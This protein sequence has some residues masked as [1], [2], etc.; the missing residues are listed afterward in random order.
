[1]LQSFSSFLDSS[2]HFIQSFINGQKL[3]HFLLLFWHKAIPAL[4]Q[5]V[6]FFVLQAKSR[7]GLP[8]STE[9]KKL[10]PLLDAL[11]LTVYLPL[12]DEGR[13]TSNNQL[14]AQEL[15]DLF[16]GTPANRQT[17]ASDKDSVRCCEN[18]H[19][20]RFCYWYY[21][22]QCMKNFWTVTWMCL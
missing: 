9:N 1:M 16:P 3:F 10:W 2:F 6:F 12:Q 21:T 13:N 8:A 11:N 5:L 7:Q 15:A 20:K 17:F 22:F 14:T 19:N 18:E 4:W